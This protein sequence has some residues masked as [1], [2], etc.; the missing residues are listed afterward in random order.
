M[1][2]EDINKE[3]VEMQAKASRLNEM[4]TTLHAALTTCYGEGHTLK[5]QPPNPNFTH[6]RDV[7]F[8]CDSC[9]AEATIVAP[10]ELTIAFDDVRE[11]VSDLWKEHGADLTKTKEELPTPDSVEGSTEVEN[12]KEY[13]LISDS[14]Q[15][16]GSYRVSL[17]DE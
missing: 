13:G 3:L 10:L 7:V 17:G 6:V 5:L 1:K 4:A 9:G 2:I 12:P 8:Y 14:K 15:G 11:S 16:D